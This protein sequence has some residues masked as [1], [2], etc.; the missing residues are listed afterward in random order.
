MGE[1]EGEGG[2]GRRCGRDPHQG[3]IKK[4]K[5]VDMQMWGRGNRFCQDFLLCSIHGNT[6]RHATCYRTCHMLQDMPHA[7]GHATCYRT[8][9]HIMWAPHNMVIPHEKE[10]HATPHDTG[11]IT[12]HDT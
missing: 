9:N 3:E 6:T 8:W 5:G 2:G 12:P 11:F 4:G 1:E 10:L 7:T